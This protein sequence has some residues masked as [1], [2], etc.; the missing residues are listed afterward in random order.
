MCKEARFREIYTSPRSFWAGALS[1]REDEGGRHPQPR[2]SG[3]LLKPTVFLLTFH[4]NVW[5]AEPDLKPDREN[6]TREMVGPRFVAKHRL[7]RAACPRLSGGPSSLPR[8]S[9]C[10]PLPPRLPFPPRLQGSGG[11]TL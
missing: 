2:F 11:S 3:V 9:P 4:S 5:K 7:A 10:E 8:G 1:G 6:Q